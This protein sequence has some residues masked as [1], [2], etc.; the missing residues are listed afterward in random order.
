MLQIDILAG[1]GSGHSISEIG[2]EINYSYAWVKANLAKSREILGA[3]SNSHA[4]VIAQSL[5]LLLGATG[6]DQRVFPF[7]I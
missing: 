1:I 4:V 3:K 5:G 2:S 7:Y 6:V